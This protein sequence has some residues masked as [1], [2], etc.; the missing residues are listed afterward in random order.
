MTIADGITTA[1]KAGKPYTLGRRIVAHRDT[2]PDTMAQ[3]HIR[4]IYEA[5][6]IFEE[7]TIYHGGDL[8][9][10]A[11]VVSRRWAQILDQALA[12]HE[13]P[14]VDS[15]GETRRS[16]SEAA[17]TFGVSV[18]AIEEHKRRKS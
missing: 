10:L 6:D 3:D 16:L 12:Y 2:S 8:D 5:T 17:D 1:L 4:P 11:R 14:V 15:I 18:A 7:K 9:E 13:T